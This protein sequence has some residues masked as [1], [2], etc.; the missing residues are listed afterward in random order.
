MLCHDCGQRV[1]TV[2]FTEVKEGRKA[3]LHLCQSCVDER[4]LPSPALNDP[5]QVD[6]VFR[7][8][9]E[10]L[11]EEEGALD[12]SHP[13]DADTCRNC[14]WSFGRFRQTGLLGCPHC[15]RGFE[16]PLGDLLR[17]LHGSAEHLG[18]EYADGP[19]LTRELDL[20]ELHQDLQV[21]ID[22]EDFELAASLRDRIQLMRDGED[23][24]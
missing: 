4:G 17:K 16:E 19:D 20:D 5:I 14:G 15:Y 21:A 24:S 12:G 13:R 23:A 9:L 1:A 10:R 2:I 6:Q 8:M 7:E 11:G 18:K 22:R 3:T